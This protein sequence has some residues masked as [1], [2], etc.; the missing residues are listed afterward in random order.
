MSASSDAVEG[1]MRKCMLVVMLLLTTALVADE[2]KSKP[3][4]KV[5]RF[6]HMDVA[7]SCLNGG[8]PTE[9]KYGNTLIISCGAD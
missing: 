4:Y 1:T 2:S 3:T 9:K 7:I 5:T 8:D 6:S